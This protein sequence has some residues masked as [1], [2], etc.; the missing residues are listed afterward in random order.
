[1]LILNVDDDID[2]REMFQAAI[3]AID[4][5]L[6]CLQFE[7]GSKALEYIANAEVAPDF[8]FIDINMP[9]MN[10]YECIEQ[11]RQIPGN[12]QIVIVMYSTAFNP[13][14]QKDYKD[15]DIT[16][17]LKKTSKFS[18]LV[19]SIKKLLSDSKVPVGKQKK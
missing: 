6:A 14:Q 9:K 4:P 8:L 12:N 2:D 19:Q 18:E 13:K 17:Y 5:N 3:N 11:I 16:T 10:G 15:L 1:M 7:S